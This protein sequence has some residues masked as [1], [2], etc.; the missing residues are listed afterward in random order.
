MLIWLW[1]VLLGFGE[2]AWLPTLSLLSST[3]FG[4]PAYGAIFG[5][6]NLT[7]NTG[8]ATGPLFA[9]LLYDATGTY[10]WV[11]VTFASLYVVGISAILLVKRPKL[12]AD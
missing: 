12:P 4:L 10:H 7:A 11:F 3:S 8:T 5:A 2:G 9:G 1:A 6:L